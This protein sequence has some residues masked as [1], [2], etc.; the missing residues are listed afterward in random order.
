MLSLAVDSDSDTSE[1]LTGELH[2][3]VEEIGSLPPEEVM[4]DDQEEIMWAG[5]LGED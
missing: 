5:I 2:W 3:S 1:D 4:A